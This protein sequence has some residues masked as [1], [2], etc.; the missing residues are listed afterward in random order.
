MAKQQQAI[1]KSKTYSMGRYTNVIWGE[2][3]D[4]EY[5]MDNSFKMSFGKVIHNMY[6]LNPKA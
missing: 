3:W 1:L 4:V 5:F 6:K 2:N